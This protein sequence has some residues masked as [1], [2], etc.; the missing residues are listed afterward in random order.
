M[1][2]NSRTPEARRRMSKAMKARWARLREHDNRYAVEDILA[3]HELCQ[4]LLAV[5]DSGTA[6]KLITQMNG[7][8][9]A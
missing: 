9:N 8:G 6:I 2:H 5:V 3:A 7:N 1:S 4:K